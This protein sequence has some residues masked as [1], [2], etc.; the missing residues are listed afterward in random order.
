[1]WHAFF[2]GA[3]TISL[4]N[5]YHFQHYVMER[6]T[7]THHLLAQDQKVMYNYEMDERTLRVV[8]LAWIQMFVVTVIQDIMLMVHIVEVILSCFMQGNIRIYHECGLEKSI[9]RITDWHHEACRVMTNC[10]RE[11]VFFLLT[12]NNPFMYFNIAPISFLIR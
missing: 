5:P 9:P 3:I 6:L 8:E 1:M 4:A 2:E 7:Q 12:I 10:D 11:N